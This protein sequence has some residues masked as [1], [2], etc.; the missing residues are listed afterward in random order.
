MRKQTFNAWLCASFIA[1]SACSVVDSGAL[2]QEAAQEYRA[3][4]AQAHKQGALDNTSATSQ[5]IQQVFRR[6]VPHAQAAN[7]TGQAFNWELA[8]IRSDELN[9]WAMPGAKWR[10]TQ[11]LWKN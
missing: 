3:T 11:A 6:M 9:A 7:K 1:L 2:N 5:R 10:C 4:V 8:V